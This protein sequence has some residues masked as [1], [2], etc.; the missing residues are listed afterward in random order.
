MLVQLVFKVKQEHVQ[1]SICVWFTR[2]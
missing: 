2:I 1:G